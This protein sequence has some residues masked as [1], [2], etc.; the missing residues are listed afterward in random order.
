MY[1]FVR[2]VYQTALAAGQPK[3]GP[4]ETH[5]SHHICWPWDID[6]FLEMNNGRVLTV[7]DLG[8]FPLAQRAGLL[9]AIRRNGWTLSMLGASVRYRRRILPFRRYQMRS[10]ALGFDARFMYL[11][12][13]IW[14]G[15]D[16]CASVLY[17]SAALHKGKMVPTQEVEAALNLTKAS[18]E[19]PAW[20]QAWIEADATRPWPPD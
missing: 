20:V 13:S 18:P 2:L 11:E 3:L 19:L 1:P 17:R 4:F 16:C 7:F 14:R 9:G 12:Q 6:I 10:R 5:V 15:E 8:R